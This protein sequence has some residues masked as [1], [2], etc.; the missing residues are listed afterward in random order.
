MRSGSVGTLKATLTGNASGFEMMLAR[1]ETKLIATS[2]VMKSVG[3]KMSLF[4]TAP[5]LLL[6]RSALKSFASFE[7]AMTQ[8]TAIMG[9]VSDEMRAKMEDTARGISKRSITSSTDLAKSYYYLASAGLDAAES[10]GA[11]GKVEQF[12][13]AG[14]FDMARATELVMDAQSALGLKSK[15]VIK[16][17]EGMVRVSDVLVKANTLAN[18]SVEQFA[19]AL[20][21]KAAASL[22]LLGK[23]VEEGVAVLA[24]FADQGVKGQVAGQRLSI[25]L[26]D[27]QRAVLTQPKVWRDM[28]LS[29]YDV[30]GEMLPLADIIGQLETKFSTMSDEEKKST[31]MML[32]FQDRSFVALQ[33][34]IGLS[35]KIRGYEAALKKAGGTTEKV[36]SKQLKSFNSQMQIAKNQIGGAAKMLG[37]SLVPYMKALAGHLVKATD[38]F[39]GLNQ[40][41]RDWIVLGAMLAAAVGPALII[42]AQFGHVVIFLSTAFKFLGFTSLKFLGILGFIIAAAALTADGLLQMT[43]KGNLG[44]ADLAANYKLFGKDAL[45]IGDSLIVSW[46]GIT[47]VWRGV[48]DGLLRLW[49]HVKFGIMESG[50]YILRGMLHVVNV[51]H[52]AF[53]WLAEKIASIFAGVGKIG[54]KF[55]GWLGILDETQ[56]AE[57]SKSISGL[58]SSIR[59]YKAAAEEGYQF[60]IEES[61]QAQLERQSSHQKEVK[62]LQ[63]EYVEDAKSYSDAIENIYSGAQ[64]AIE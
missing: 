50:G 5:L 52:G 53:T 59:A 45:T 11:L 9:D 62:R 17:T 39:K 14:R 25:V 24:A 23:D 13:V 7:D 34:L 4:V 51:I 29:V 57:Y 1:A 2:A 48:G 64:K 43:G 31:A 54:V 26:R 60:K 37:K 18:A 27:L 8:S 16:N 21:N 36:A 28:G 46:L 15:D 33:M 38:W 20:T 22:K 61:L 19:D 32:G 56:V 35:D 6:G 41:T 40:G 58:T 44:I 12:A 10:I 30:M 63:Q 47:Q 42:M 55:A 49:E 3:M